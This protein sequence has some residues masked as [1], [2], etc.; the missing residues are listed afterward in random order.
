MVFKGR[1]A[2]NLTR[3]TPAPSNASWPAAT[4]GALAVALAAALCALVLGVFARFKS[5]AAAPL[6]V[7]EYFI[8]R[9]VQNL[10]HH[11]L[12]LFDCG[13]A[14]TRALVLQYLAAGLDILGFPAEIAPR[15][16]SATCSVIALP[17]AY[18]LGRRVS[19]P[20]VGLLAVA[21]LALSVWETEMGRFGR[22]YAPFQAVFLWYLVFFL[23]RTVDRDSR[24][25]WG[26]IALTV[27]GALLWEGGV[28]LAVANFL[29]PFLQHGSLKLPKQEWLGLLKYA[30]VLVAAGWFI[31]TD[32]RML[33]GTPALPGDYDPSGAAGLADFLQSGPQLWQVLRSNPAWM[34]LLALPL[35]A[36]LTAVRALWRRGAADLTAAGLLA[37]LVA[38]L[39]HQFLAVAA[40]IL[41]LLLLRFSSWQELRSPPARTV[42]VA[43]GVCALFWC[44]LT[45]ASWT[46]PAAG[47][48]WKAVAASIYPLVSFP[49][50][51]GQV[52]H[53][54]AAAV[55]ALGLGLAFLVGMSLIH[56]LR[57]SEN[58]LTDERALLVVWL[59]LL[60]AA[61]SS[62]PI[63]HETRYVFFLY[64][65][66]I[67][68]SLT[69]VVRLASG[70]RA[71]RRIAVL[72]P[73]LC[74]GLFAM[75]EDF[76]LGHLFRIDSPAVIYQA[77]ATP[78][79]QE[80]LVVRDDTRALANW[81]SL[82]AGGAGSVVISAFQSLDYYYPQVAYFYVDR[83]DFNFEAYACR[84]GTL[85]RWS[86]R[87]LLQ[88]VAALETL[89][90]RQPQT[91]LVTYSARLG[92]LLAQLAR[93]RPRV[94][95]ST[96]HLS[97]VTF[98][99]GQPRA[100]GAF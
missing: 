47:S 41:L 75:S 6:A 64:P 96:D 7:D 84:R 59:C 9:S 100:T 16:I 4:G 76:Q 56:S 21:V 99:A 38:A 46:G 93:D 72:V 83:G 50:L 87:P 61:C 89:I 62:S 15:M 11:G 54:W 20:V 22:M 14:Y 48:T 52:V 85:E 74:L 33:G 60:L 30:G 51:L 66:A 29:P 2:A 68:L 98:D 79:K 40:I 57:Y 5:L 69:A 97:V 36:T 34:A 67:V 80:H 91:R 3:I 44:I 70:L 31:G 13:G 25:D 77:Q 23:R 32:F 18:V 39:A 58:G 63:R 90:R 43:I 73:V 26:L 17:A 78:A 10:L 94:E 53:P 86:N 45:G 88:S 37:A 95:W 81:L 28:F 49:D 19:G 71:D 8:V 35:G 12:P 65:V 82:H 27:L 24:A 55:P 42:Y 92:P 1:Q